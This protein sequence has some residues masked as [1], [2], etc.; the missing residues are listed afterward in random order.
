M[1]SWAPGA[2]PRGSR[3]LTKSNTE[4]PRSELAPEPHI[5]MGFVSLIK[6]I[7]FGLRSPIPNL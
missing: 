6:L 3:A 4:V 7:F 5:G 2:I 1:R